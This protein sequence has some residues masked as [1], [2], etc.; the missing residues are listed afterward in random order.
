MDKVR[1][2]GGAVVRE[3]SKAGEMGWSAHVKDTEGNVVGAWQ[4]LNPPAQWLFLNHYRVARTEMFK[5]SLL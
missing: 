3:K 5:Y 4:Q 2:S 1:Q